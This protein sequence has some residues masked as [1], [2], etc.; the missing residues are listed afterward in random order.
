MSNDPNSFMKY[1]V[2]QAGGNLPGFHGSPVYYGRGIGSLFSR[3]FRFV[4]PLLK[5]GFSL[6]KPHLK[7]AVSGIASDV[8]GKAVSRMTMTSEEEGQAGQ[9]ISVLSRKHRK[10]PPGQ[11]IWTVKKQP[12]KKKKT[13]VSSG[14]RK[15]RKTLRQADIF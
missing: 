11:R 4:T 9:G 2:T 10:R 3:L 5:Q 7:K 1:Y 13:S 8:L 14:K 6:A 15:R 12:A